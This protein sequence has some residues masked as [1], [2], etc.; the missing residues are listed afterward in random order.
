MHSPCA[1]SYTHLLA[2]GEART[3]RELTECISTDYLAVFQ[4][5]Y[6]PDES[7]VRKKLREYEQLGLL[8]SEKQGR[9]LYY[10]RDTMFVGLGSWQ[11]AAAFFSEAAPLGVIGSYL[12]DRGESCADF[13]GFKHHYMLHVLDLSLIHI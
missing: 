5:D 10:R 8:V 6:E 1:V 11:E 3:V 4:S 13:F 9:E 2:E 7:T 12:L